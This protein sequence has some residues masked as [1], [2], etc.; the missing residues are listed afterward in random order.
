MLHVYTSPAP[1]S[2]HPRAVDRVVPAVHLVTRAIMAHST[3]SDQ[4]RPTHEAHAMSTIDSLTPEGRFCRAIAGSTAQRRDAYIAAAHIVA[5]SPDWSR[6]D[7]GALILAAVAA[8]L[9]CTTDAA[10]SLLFQGDHS[11]KSARSAAGKAVALGAQIAK[12]FP[13]QATDSIQVLT[14]YLDSL[15]LR[16]AWAVELYFKKE[17]NKNVKPLWERVLR[18]LATADADGESESVTEAVQIALTFAAGDAIKLSKEVRFQRI[19]LPAE[20]PVEEPLAA[21]AAE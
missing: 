13:E 20:T 1:S 8:T 17:S 4:N 21:A 19:N 5:H 3:D 6:N 18:M 11:A 7:A 15:D 12:R 9:G 16:T 10:G 14:R 2:R